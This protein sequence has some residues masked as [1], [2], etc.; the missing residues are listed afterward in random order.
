[1]ADLKYIMDMA[2]DEDLG[3]DKYSRQPSVS[4]SARSP[5][6]SSTTKQSD[7]SLPPSNPDPSKSQQKRRTP[8]SRSSRPTTTV[9]PTTA[10][11]S[12]DKASS[13]RHPFPE[14]R[15]VDSTESMDPAGY[16]SYAQSSSS[17]TMPPSSRSNVST[18]PM[19]SAPGESNIPVKLTPITGRVSRAKKGVPVHTCEICKPPKTFTRAEHLRRHQLSH[20]PATFQCPYHGCDKAFHRQDLLTR[21]TQRH[22][23]DDRSGTDLTGTTSRQTSHTPVERNPSMSGFLQ[24]PMLPG[25]NLSIAD[26]MSANTSYPGS[27]SPYSASHRGSI[28]GQGPMSPSAHS[29]RSSHSAGPSQDGDYILSSTTN[30]HVPPF[31]MHASSMDGS[32]FHSNSYGLEFQPRRSPSYAYMGL[33]GLPSLTI[34]DSSFPGHLSESNWPSSASGSPYSTPDRIRGYESP[35]TDIANH[36]MYYVPH[37]FHSPQQ[38]VYH[39]VSDYTYPDDTGYYDFQSHPFP[40]RNPILPTVTLS[41][42]PTE[43]LVTLGHAV[44]DASAILGRQ[45]TLSPYAGSTFPLPAALNAIPRYLDVYWKRFDTLFPLVHRWSLGNSDDPVL[46]CAMAALGSQF[47]QN[48]EDRINGHFLHGVASQEVRRRP[49]WSIQV[50]QTI[51]LCEFYGR[52]RGSKAVSRP[53]ELFQSLYSRDHL[54][55]LVLSP[56]NNYWHQYS[57]SS[58]QVA[59]PQTSVD[60]D[61][62]ISTS[63]RHWDEWIRT[64]SRRRLH[65]ACFILDI[66]TS[67]YHEHSSLHPSIYLEHS[68][69]H[70][71]LAPT[72]PIPLIRSTKDLWVAPDP[73]AWQE[74]LSSDPDQLNSTSLP[75]EEITP[76]HVTKA[77]PLDLAVY[78]ASETLRLR[79]RSSASSLDI[80]ADLDLESTKRLSILFP[81]NAVANTYLALHYTPLRDLLAVSG[82]SWLFSRKLLDQEDF[83]RRKVIVR[84]WSSSVHAGAAS[85]FAAKALLAFFDI[86]DASNTPNDHDSTGGNRQGGGWNMSEISDYWA[87]YVCALI[88]W[89]LGHSL[90]HRTMRG[91]VG[92]GGADGTG[93]SATSTQNNNSASGKGESEAKGWLKMLASSSPE[94]AIQNVQAR[95]EALGVIA[96]VRRRLES[97]T[98]GGKSKLLVDA[99]RVLKSLEEDPNRGRF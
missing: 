11:A 80:T 56:S 86:N 40:V 1:M 94:A 88:C 22:E 12:V 32:P 73:E 63:H 41:A 29:T 54:F 85:T 34:P 46:R 76:D 33:E 26:D 4:G 36:D 64:E 72:P 49:Q 10:T 50:M 61:T 51:L 77:L 59:A 91:A 13:S 20:K 23:Q 16:G 92:R 37:Q 15:S 95:R 21:H 19:S 14:R 17:S 53:S 35:N 60:Q 93:F 67:M 57:T 69:L 70:N 62:S 31:G 58:S 52:F 48:K 82:D 25:N 89:S 28:S 8:L 24:P 65:A 2:D 5:N 18:R 99:V 27:A 45:K 6:P 39:P 44:S 81:E 98:I 75:D 3:N 84:S 43:N 97:E 55:S 47:L 7:D 79:R 78:L 30:H 68:S 38:P 9:P 96:M 71:F 83:Q 42:Q 90:G 66:H 87:L 74:L